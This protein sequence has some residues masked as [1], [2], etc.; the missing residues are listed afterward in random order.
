MCAN[1]RTC[2]RAFVNTHSVWMFARM[3]ELGMGL[4]LFSLPIT[5]QTVSEG[6]SDLSLSQDP[7][8]STWPGSKLSSKIDSFVVLPPTSSPTPPYLSRII[9]GGLGYLQGEMSG[10]CEQSH[11]PLSSIHSTPTRDIADI[12]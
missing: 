1:V 8:L 12:R 5:W 3:F 7:T 11:L 9:P 6:A 2:F 4:Y 10:V